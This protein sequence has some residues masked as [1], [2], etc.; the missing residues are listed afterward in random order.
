MVCF[1]H[2]MW[3]D[4][5]MYE[6]CLSPLITLLALDLVFAIVHIYMQFLLRFQFCPFSTWCEQDK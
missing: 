6:Y 5:Y 3:I 1:A 4:D 2:L